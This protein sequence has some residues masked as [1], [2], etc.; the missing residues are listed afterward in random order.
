MHNVKK[1]APV[2]HGETEMTLSSSVI[3]IDGCGN[4]EAEWQTLNT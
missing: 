3:V 1:Q 4:A 2:S